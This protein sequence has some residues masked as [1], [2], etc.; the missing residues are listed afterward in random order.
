MTKEEII[1]RVSDRLQ[2]VFDEIRTVYNEWY[3]RSK[4]LIQEAYRIATEECSERSLCAY[5]KRTG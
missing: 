2:K 5:E 1:P 3:G 4:K